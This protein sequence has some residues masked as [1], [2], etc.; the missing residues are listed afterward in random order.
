MNDYV[1]LGILVIALIISLLIAKKDYKNWY[2]SDG[3]YK[4]YIIRAIVIISLGVIL[5]LWKIFKS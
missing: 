1:G 4:S 5:L 3:V 2:D